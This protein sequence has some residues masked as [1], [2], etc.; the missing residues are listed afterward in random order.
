MDRIKDVIIYVLFL[1]PMIRR[2]SMG[3]SHKKKEIRAV[4]FM[5][6]HHDIDSKIDDQIDEVC[7]RLMNL[8]SN[9]KY[10]DID[11]ELLNVDIKSTPSDVL[12]AYL[13]YTH[14]VRDHLESRLFFMICC[15]AE[16][17][18]REEMDDN[19]RLCFTRLV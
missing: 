7:D 18:L 5:T 14:P 12:V 11:T 19:M 9:D 15:A 16:I 1:D 8:L 3:W 10:D 6:E 13:A 4:I 17:E 2:D